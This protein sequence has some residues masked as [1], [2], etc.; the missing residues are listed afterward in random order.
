MEGWQI[1]IGKNANNNDLLTQKYAKK[2]DL[3]LHARDVAGSHVIIRKRSGMVFPKNI[4]ER[5]AE[6]AAFYSKRK[7]DTVCSVIVTQ[8]KYV[9]K[10]KNMAAGKVIVDKEETLLVVPKGPN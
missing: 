4:I 5:A 8:K 1:W 3:W 9:R 2:D 10:P 6:L 7:T